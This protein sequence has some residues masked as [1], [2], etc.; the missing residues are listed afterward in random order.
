MVM[1]PRTHPRGAAPDFTLPKKNPSSYQTDALWWLV[2]MRLLLVPG[3]ANGGTYANKPGSHNIGRQL[4]TSDHSLNPASI[5]RTG[6]WW[7]DKCSA[8]DWTFLNAQRGD[9]STI[10]LYTDRLMDAMERG[11]ARADLAYHYTIGQR[12]KDRVVEAYQEI[13]EEAFT[14][15]DMSHLWHRHDSFRRDR[16]GDFWVMWAALTIDMGWTEAEWRRSLPEAAPK[17]PTTTPSK[18]VVSR[19]PVVALGHRVV[20]LKSPAMRGTDVRFIQKFI[21][22]KHCGT[23]DGIFGSKTKSGVIWYQ[24]LRGIKKDGEV[25]PVTW[26]NMGVRWTG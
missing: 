7:R 8:H 18:P 11:D 17:P 3:T 24:G 10:S 9:Y 2:Q 6:P 4:P 12:D 16:V 23:A 14:S 20:E 25:G 26:R 22:E 15:S 21:G 1:N 5:N 13:K 19:L